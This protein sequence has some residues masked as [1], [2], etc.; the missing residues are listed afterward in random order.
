MTQDEMDMIYGRTAR[1]KREAERTLVC[2]KRKAEAMEEAMRRVAVD[3][4]FNALE[5]KLPQTALDN[6]P[7]KRDVIDL[8]KQLQDADRKV[9][10]LLERLQE[11][12]S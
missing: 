7:E 4:T 9:A 10:M 12:E 6:F 1:E 11:M 2:L 5:E 3:F 8:A